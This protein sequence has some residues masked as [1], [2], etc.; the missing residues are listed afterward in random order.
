MCN[1]LSILQFLQL[2]RVTI[3]PRIIP[4]YKASL[5]HVL[6]LTRMS[7]CFYNCMA[8]VMFHFSLLGHAMFCA[9]KL[10]RSCRLCGKNINEQRTFFI[11]G[12]FHERVLPHCASPHPNMRPYTHSRNTEAPYTTY[13]YGEDGPSQR[14]D[15]SK[16]KC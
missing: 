13:T 9:L 15:A 1:P 14:R 5:K 11:L 2:I 4:T 16:R 6:K 12:H 8:N 7:Y 3:T 10:T